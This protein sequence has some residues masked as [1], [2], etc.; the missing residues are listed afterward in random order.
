MWKVRKWKHFTDDGYLVLN[1][2]CPRCG[3]EAVIKCSFGGYS[4]QIFY[5]KNGRTKKANIVH[6]E[7]FGPIFVS[8]SS[9]KKTRK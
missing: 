7:I 3:A 1:Y 5:E 4:G 9:R 2:E 8:P 6:S